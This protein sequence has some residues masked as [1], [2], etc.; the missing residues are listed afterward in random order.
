MSGAT[1][2]PQ[3]GTT[4][5][6]GDAGGLSNARSCHIY[7]GR[8]GWRD[9]GTWLLSPTSPPYR[10]RQPRTVFIDHAGTMAPIPPQKKG[11]PS[12]T[13]SQKPSL[14]SPRPDRFAGLRNQER[15]ENTPQQAAKSRQSSVS[16]PAGTRTGTP[17]P[18]KGPAASP[19]GLQET[20]SVRGAADIDSSEQTESSAKDARAPAEDNTEEGGGGA[21]I[22]NTIVSAHQ[23]E[24]WRIE[25]RVQQKMSER[26]AQF[27]NNHASPAYEAMLEHERGPADGEEGV[28]LKEGCKKYVNPLYRCTQCLHSVQM[29]AE[30]IVEMHKN[31]PFHV[32]ERWDRGVGFWERC[33]LGSLGLQI[34]LGHRGD[35]C[36]YSMYNR[37][38]TV[39]HERGID[40]ITINYCGCRNVNTPQ[41]TQLLSVGL[42][43]SSWQ[44]PQTVF[45]FHMMEQL[46]LLSV[47]AHTSTFDYFKS[48]T[49]L[50]NRVFPEDCKVRPAAR[51]L[52]GY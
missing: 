3:I 47:I 42:W 27:I 34:N 30:H 11:P 49:E 9:R 40:T 15:S 35:K 18:E 21:K 37:E 28:C 50:T 46:Q 12:S 17:N 25:L 19:E 1:R 23:V 24:L 51:P 14:S 10:P 29:C 22:N 39:V 52:A 45:T 43:P 13:P 44:K 5:T 16:T 20:S 32:V 7:R 48:V 26:M 4:S 31:L 36:L 38:T 41:S 6:L 2:S 33:S 8:A